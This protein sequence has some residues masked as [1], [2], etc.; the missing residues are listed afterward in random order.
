MTT[1][2]DQQYQDLIVAEV[3]DDAAGTLALNVPLYWARRDGITD[4]ETR[5]LYVKRDAI[6]LMLGRVR[7][8]VRIVGVG[9]ASIDAH[10][11]TT[12]LQDMRAAVQTLIDT[13]ID[14]A[15]AGGAAGE[16]T[17]TAPIAPPDGSFVDANN[18]LYR[19]D[20]YERRRR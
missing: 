9:G 7:G 12:H 16:L 3:G 4:L 8:Q 2:S 6:N 10:Q 13:G 5:H 19:G 18:R 17:T 20:P 14:A 1:L 15:S 11:L